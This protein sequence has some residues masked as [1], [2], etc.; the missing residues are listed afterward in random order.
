[1]AALQRTI[2]ASTSRPCITR[3]APSS[4]CQ[5]PDV[6]PHQETDMLI[7]YVTLCH[8]PPAAPI[9]PSILQ[10]DHSKRSLRSRSIARRITLRFCFSEYCVQGINRREDLRLTRAMMFV[11][12]SGVALVVKPREYSSSPMTLMFLL[13]THVFDMHTFRVRR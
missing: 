9:F 6:F 3:G 5:C 2:V 8:W 13:H 10:V 11:R 12:L 1:M 7:S 4:R